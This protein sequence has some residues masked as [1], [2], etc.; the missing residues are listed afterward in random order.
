MQLNGGLGLYSNEGLTSTTCVRY[1]V[2]IYVEHHEFP[3]DSNGE[4]DIDIKLQAKNKNP[5][6]NR[7]FKESLKER[8]VYEREDRGTIINTY[9]LGIFNPQKGANDLGLLTEPIATDPDKGQD[10]AYEIVASDPV[11][12]NTTLFGISQCS[13]ELFTRA[14]LNYDNS[15]GN[16]DD[17]GKY[18]LCIKVCD[19][20]TFF[21]G[22]TVGLCAD[23]T[24]INNDTLCGTN[25]FKTTCDQAG[26]VCVVVK[27][28]NVN[29]PPYFNLTAPTNLAIDEQMPANTTV[30][31]GNMHNLVVD[32]DDPA[33]KYLTFGIECLSCPIVKITTVF[34]TSD[35]KVSAKAHGL[36]TGAVIQVA[37]VLGMPELSLPYKYYTITVTDFNT[38]LLNVDTRNFASGTVGTGGSATH[39]YL[40]L[41]SDGILRCT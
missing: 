1:I 37:N 3:N 24:G 21:E 32:P 4:C 40:T 34:R 29:D 16:G 8:A 39:M 41:L 7:N 10:L 15:P 11:G 35:G 14:T 23:N 26:G 36:Q 25:S 9:D 30:T 33:G 38:F 31:H 18:Y 6:F 22:E 20:P 5:V 19:D 13:G 27:V 12:A 28:V 17:K 2:K